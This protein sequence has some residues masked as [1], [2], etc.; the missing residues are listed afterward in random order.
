MDA[1]SFASL[2]PWA[3]SP[4]L[5]TERGVSTIVLETPIRLGERRRG[6]GENAVG[7]EAPSIP[8]HEEQGEQSNGG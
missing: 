1:I 3:T 7:L 5:R 6:H 2:S 4:G 8:N